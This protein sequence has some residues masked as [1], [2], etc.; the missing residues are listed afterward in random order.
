M[1]VDEDVGRFEIAVE[2]APGMGIIDG[3]SQWL[4]R[5]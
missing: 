3:L 5:P 4:G 1:L 2:D